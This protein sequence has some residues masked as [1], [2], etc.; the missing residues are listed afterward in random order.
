MGVG[1]PIE[2]LLATDRR[3][4]VVAE[5]QRDRRSHQSTA[6]QLG[7]RPLAEPIERRI[8]LGMGD[9]VPVERLLVAERLA[10]ARLA[11]HRPVILPTGARLQPAGVAPNDVEQQHARRDGQIRQRHDPGGA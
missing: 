4:V 9:D 3:K 5:L 8:Q 6:A 7:P 10:L 1:R 11:T 2:R